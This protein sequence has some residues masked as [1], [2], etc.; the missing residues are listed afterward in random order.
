MADEKQSKMLRADVGQPVELL[1]PDLAHS[2]T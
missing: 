2:P 1:T